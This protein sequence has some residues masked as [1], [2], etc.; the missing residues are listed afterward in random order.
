MPFADA[1]FDAVFSKDALIHITDKAAIYSEILRVL[2]PGGPV[3]ASDWLG[4]SEAMEIPSFRRYVDLAQLG[5]EM[6][7][8]TQTEAAMRQAGFVDVSSL[9]RNQW[10][11]GLAR[12]EVTE[13]AGPLRHQL[14]EVVGEDIYN[15]WL[16]VRTALAEATEQG[17][18]RPTHLRGYKPA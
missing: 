3:A 10:Y 15:H 12:Q 1:E 5:F 11:A 6:A 18:L 9:D 7:T 17:G 14:L 8:A 13:I 2:K 16:E 4:S